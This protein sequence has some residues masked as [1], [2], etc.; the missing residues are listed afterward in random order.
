MIIEKQYRKLSD[1]QHVLLRPG[2]YIGSVVNHT[3]ISWFLDNENNMVKR[4]GTWNPALLKLFDEVLSNSVDESKRK[5]SKLNRIDVLINQASGILSVKDNGG[6]PV[7]IH[8]EAKQYVPEM[9]FSEL[10]AGSNFEDTADNDLTGQNGEGAALTNIFSNEFRVTTCDGKNQFVQ[11]FTDNMSKRTKPDIRKCTVNGTKIQWIPD[12]VRLNTNLKGDNFQ[13]MVKRVHDVAACNPKLIVYLNGARIKY[14]SFKSYISTYT[15]DFVYG[16][17]GDWQVGIAASEDGFQQVSFVNTSETLSGGTHVEYIEAQVNR[18][19]REYIK[20]KH[21]V[22]VKPAVIRTHLMLFVNARIINPRYPSQTKEDLL[23]EP[24]DFGT[25]YE[26]SDKL[27]AD[28]VKGNI[29]QSILDWVASKQRQEE[30]AKLRKAARNNKSKK[31]AAHIQANST[32]VSDTILHLME[33]ESAISNF[34]NVRNQ[35]IHGAYPLKGK[36]LNWR[37]A[38]SFAD[39]ALN[40]E[41]SS[42]MNI[43]G[44]EFGKTATLLKYGKIRYSTDADLDGAGSIVG[45]LNNFFSMWPELFDGRIEILR[46]PIIIARKQGEEN[47]C[48]YTLAEYDEV[49]EEYTE[50]N[51]KY[52][53]GLGGLTEDEYDFMINSPRIDTVKMGEDGQLAL[54]MAFGK[55][56]EGRKK[57]LIRT[58]TKN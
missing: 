56:V 37:N 9:I 35:S 3:G 31:V 11:V 44:L 6:I 27:I 17:N 54:E 10:R 8:K 19:V 14:A 24:R 18:K 33:G 41:Y 51:I 38:K 40:E 43:L 4:E 13:K 26:V 47:V 57:W 46:S 58:I 45:L 50:W 16:N 30:M 1:V 15:S 7:V 25:E 29:I 53:K 55:D 52:V 36:P 21:K 32:K 48:F 22:D 2:R 23:T 34:I 20:K 49:Q 42:I 28:I 5:G 12:Y 39:V